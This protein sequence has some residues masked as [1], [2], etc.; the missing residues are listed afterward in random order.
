[1]T[2]TGH[3]RALGPEGLS[4]LLRLR[5]EIGIP[6]PRS[7]QEL[8]ARTR[9]PGLLKIALHRLNV[10]ALQVAEAL[11]ALG[12][13]ADRARLAALLGTGRDGSPG[14]TGGGGLTALDR[15][16]A[17]L[18]DHFLL[19][20]GPDG[21]CS[22]LLPEL[23]DL[24][25]RPL[26]L[27][28]PLEALAPTRS[29]EELRSVLRF[30]AEPAPAHK[31]EL[32]SRVVA[33]LSDADRVRRLLGGA[34]AGLAERLVNIAHGREE[35]SYFTWSGAR[36]SRGREESSDPV[37]WAIVR[38]LLVPS[39]WGGG[40]IMPAEVA[41]AL[42]GPGWTAP[43]DP[44]A[45]PVDWITHPAATVASAAT[46]AASTALRTVA[47]ILTSAGDRPLP[48]LK[49]GAVGVRE[50][51]RYAAAAGCT[52]PEVRLGLTLACQLQLLSTGDEGFA[53]TPLHD[54]WRSLPAALRYADLVA[55]WSLLPSMPFADSDGPWAPGASQPFTEER[56]R[57]VLEVLAGHPQAAPARLE[58]FHARVRWE[59]YLLFGTHPASVVGAVLGEAAWL[60]ITGAGALS[61]AGA[62]VLAGD[63]VAAVMGTAL[64]TAQDTARL[65]TDLTAVTLGEPS[66]S[67]AETLDAMADRENR[68]T[69]TVWRFSPGS[70]RRALD[71]GSDAATLLDRLRALAE[72]PV[73]QPLEY[74]VHDV[75]R[76]HGAVRG[77]LIACYLR[78][79]DPA[80]LAELAADRRLARLGLRQV[81][82]TVL[83]GCRPLPETLGALRAAGHAPVEE[84]PDGAPIVSRDRRH[85]ADGPPVSRPS[86]GAPCDHLPI[87]PDV[88][89]RTPGQEPAALAAALLSADDEASGDLVDVGATVIEITR[90][91]LHHLW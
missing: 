44:G 18:R 83:V 42:R 32:V 85:R 59:A 37:T 19:E 17:T 34:P 88:P 50:L 9:H 14:R 27:A 36:H 87:P 13:R 45:P 38:F 86:H 48:R 55:A 76:R 3:L 64:G 72:G 51:R 80:L 81:A 40:L 68:S 21:A 79:D 61:P 26:G 25:A 63:D 46:A 56:R 10:P 12:S 41:L 71:A 60:G 82:P 20:P 6:P 49:S 73:P 47:G 11:A 30:L 5:P 4:R 69:A 43:F 90:E 15:S 24:W 22:P 33:A 65:Q 62:A 29:V 31:P 39:V 89:L 28:E 2:L 8:E 52:M 16:L 70:V 58:P 75:A 23:R 1:M 78:S 57:I 7:L 67:L 54:Q 84:G 66:A 74:L 53:P 77:G 35:I 91:G